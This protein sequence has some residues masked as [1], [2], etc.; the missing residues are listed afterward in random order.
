MIPLRKK[1]Y[2]LHSKDGAFSKFKKNH[3]IVKANNGCIIKALQSDKGGEYISTRFE[4]SCRAHGIKCEA[5]TS[6][7]PQQKWLCQISQ[8]FIN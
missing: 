3:Q 8:P 1:N 2:F 7:T 5:T 6:H 4:E